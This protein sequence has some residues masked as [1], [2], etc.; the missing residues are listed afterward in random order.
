[1]DSSKKKAWLKKWPNTD[2][3]QNQPTA[4]MWSWFF[5]LRTGKRNCEL[6]RGNGEWGHE[7]ENGER[8]SASQKVPRLKA[9]A[10][11]ETPSSFS[12]S[13]AQAKQSG[14]GK[15][16]SSQWGSCREWNRSHTKGSEAKPAISPPHTLFHTQWQLQRRDKF[17]GIV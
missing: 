14:E 2:T 10:H 8:Y 15:N 13:M 11:T 7:E 16:S 17:G 1:M 4:C 5:E 9:S 3:H 12:V 6:T